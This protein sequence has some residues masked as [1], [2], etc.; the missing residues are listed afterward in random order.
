MLEDA[1]GIN[2]QASNFL[3]SFQFFIPR[4]VN[5]RMLLRTQLT[6]Y[7]LAGMLGLLVS[8]DNQE[9]VDYASLIQKFNRWLMTAFASE[10]TLYATGV[11]LEREMAELSMKETTGATPIGRRGPSPPTAPI[12][13]LT[14][15]SAPKGITKT[16]CMSRHATTSKDFLAHVVDLIYPRPV[17]W[18]LI[19]GGGV[20]IACKKLRRPELN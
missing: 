19:D 8:G 6:R 1:K 7:P 17:S 18:S 2:C 14:Q 5:S 13:P 16:E 15:I 4:C 11:P 3:K 12:P 9:K 10:D 20:L